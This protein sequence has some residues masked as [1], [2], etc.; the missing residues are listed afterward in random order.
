MIRA[1][2]DRRVGD[3][4][5]AIVDT[6]GVVDLDRRA[7]VGLAALIDATS[8]EQFEAPTPCPDWTVQALLAHV[9]A[10]NLKY[11]EIALGRDWSRGAPEIELDDDPAAMY[12]R[13][14]GAMLEA[15]ERPGAL[16]R[17][18]PL[19]LGRGPAEAALYLHLGEILVHG[20]DLAM[21]AGQ[22]PAFDDDV[23]EASLTQFSSWLPPQ[24][25]PGSPFSDATLLGEDAAA[26]DRLAA[27]LGRNVS[28]W[29]P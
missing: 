5:V 10:G 27:Y 7:A 15:W 11:T 18:T 17:E 9:V 3:G 20:W 21:A 8:I 29:S 16:E 26:V 4:A 28:A 13:T 24:R 6:V 14:V 23:V 2:P 22:R 1:S 12:R 25:P 19:P